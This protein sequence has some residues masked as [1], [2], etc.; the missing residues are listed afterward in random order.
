MKFL[1]PIFVFVV[2]GCGGGAKEVQHVTVPAGKVVPGTRPHGPQAFLGPVRRVRAGAITIGYRQVGFGPPLLLVMGQNATMNA[3]GSRLPGLLAQTF[4]VTMFDNRGVGYSTDQPWLPL[5]IEQMA[6][7]TAAL[8][9]ALSI[10]KAMVVGWSTGGEIALSL[11]ENRPDKVQGLVL[12]GATA[13]GPTAV[14]PSAE[15]Q[16][17]F[18]SNAPGVQ[19]KLLGFL[20]PPSAR[21]ALGIYLHDMF[22]LP[23]DRISPRTLARQAAAEE[24]FARTNDTYAALPAIQ[25]PTV[26]ANGA[27]DPL[28]PAQNARIIAARIP[29]AR[30]AIFPGA[31]HAM[32]FQD[33]GRFV[34]L[35]RRLVSGTQTRNAADTAVRASLLRGV[36]EIRAMR[37]DENLHAELRRAIASVRSARPS[38]S[39]GR[40][41]RSLAIQGFAA[42]LR[43]VERRLAFSKNDSGNV[44]AATRDARAADRSLKNGANLL[45]AAGRALGVHVGDLNGW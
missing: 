7:D 24:R 5:T 1:L 4:R 40:R 33:V 19:R 28:V 11:A 29:H 37:N 17:L 30:L 27:L 14:Q 20:F 3:W 36:A 2:A 34:E 43:G 8:L 18:T 45:R 44:E 15:V 26:V 35:V 23:R 9:D 32:M 22:A 38:T 39:A 12:V 6:D 21:M 10:A 41:A 42:M 13:G 31:S 25:A 16:A